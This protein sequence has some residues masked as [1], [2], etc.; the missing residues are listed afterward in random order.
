MGNVEELRRRL[1]D[2]KREGPLPLLVRTRIR[3]F[4]TALPPH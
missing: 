4:W 2:W 1:G 3:T